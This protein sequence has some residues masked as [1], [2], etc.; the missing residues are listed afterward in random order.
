MNLRVA[1]G[2]PLRLLAFGGL[3]AFAGATWF[4]LVEDPPLGRA[5]LVLATVLAGGATL[6]ALGRKRIHPAPTLLLGLAAAALMFGLA[7]LAAGLPLRLLVP[8]GWDELGAR[9]DPALARMDHIDL[10]YGGDGRWVRLG[11]LLGAPLFLAPTAA[12]AFW[13]RRRASDRLPV[14][15]L[16]VLLAMYAV[17]VGWHRRDAELLLGFSLL[18][19]I[20][21]WVW[22]P[23]L[24]PRR[25]PAAATLVALAGIAALPLAARL[26]AE[27]PW[28]DYRSWNWFGGAARVSFDWSHSYGPLDWRR[29]GT[30]LLEIRSRKSQYWKAEVLDHFDG[31]RWERSNFEGLPL[32][33]P[34]FQG[35]PV[36][37]R[38]TRWLQRAEVT[39]RALRSRFVIG[40]GTIRELDGAGT[41]LPD[42]DG[43]TRTDGPPLASGDSYTVLSY[44]PEPSLAQLRQA[45][46]R[47][48]RGL[49]PY[50]SLAIPGA[51]PAAAEL[52]EP[53]TLTMPIWG[54][55]GSG[56]RGADRRLAGSPHGAVLRL[57]RRLT[58]GAPTPYAAVAAVERYLGGE[59]RY[60]ENP[61]TR[62]QPLPAFL[63]RDK[64][65]YC[66]Q[67]SGAM[68]LLLRMAGLPSRV[69]AGFAPGT[70]DRE[71]LWR[72]VDYDAHSWVEVY[73]NG[74]GWVAFDPTPSIAP[75]RAQF[76][77]GSVLPGPPRGTAVE[78]G[79]PGRA[80]EE[81]T[82]A[83][84]T[85]RT[86]GGATSTVW[87]WTRALALL[88]LAAAA[89]A[90]ASLALRR[91]R[92]L[93]SGTTIE[94]QLRELG[95]ALR[96]RG[97]SPSAGSTLLALEQR[98][99]KIAGPAASAYV[100]ALR[101]SRYAPGHPDPPGPS[102]RRAFR[103]ELTAGRG[104]RARMRAYRRI[105]PGGPRL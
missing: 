7:L 52:G 8:G 28:L 29:E 41:A 33:S 25:L 16:V 94:P 51:R 89:L 84:P 79:R 69:V 43:T 39:V 3:A 35:P 103:R 14:A 96:G 98:L 61:P 49:D 64:R 102:E 81:R 50:T 59:F 13:P 93:A 68:A 48:P 54:D 30:T 77:L 4:S 70:A 65:G 91:H 38:H 32:A 19:L 55:P 12:L 78:A 10:P 83:G 26:D 22:L 80:R 101:T 72:V 66:Q 67:F 17:A 45:P 71:G 2:L 63:F 58:A 53:E 104:L 57:A 1:A 36:A 40:P 92:R 23:R 76:S 85:A 73:F 11:I 62:A 6:G 88:A 105:P 46:A 86:A 87:T 99:A 24:E 97:W 9:L 31:V 56:S 20:G 44:V 21:A 95:A 37:Y 47:Y 75:A 15:A 27:E 60:D 74:I 42:S 100:A 34:R 82:G 18:L 90:Y 5:A